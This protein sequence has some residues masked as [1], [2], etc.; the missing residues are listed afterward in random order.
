MDIRRAVG[1]VFFMAMLSLATGACTAD[2]DAVSPA[3]SPAQLIETVNKALADPRI[4]TQE[5]ARLL[6][7]R[8]L[9]REMLGERDDA[10]ADFT[11]AIAARALGTEEQA[12]ALYDRGVTLDELGRVDDAIA[13]YT[14]ALQ[15][16][17]TFA[18]AFNNRG[19][20][21]RRLGRLAEARRDYEASM[22]AGNPHSEYPEYGMGQIA[23]ALDQPSAAREYYRSALA[24]NPQFALAEE[25]L[26]A[27]DVGSLSPI[28]VKKP[29]HRRAVALRRPAASASSD[30]GP[31]LKPTINDADAAAGPY[32]QLGAYRTTGEANEAWDRVQQGAG[33]LL[34]GLTPVIVAIDLRGRGRYYR[35]RVAQPSPATA[36]HLCQALRAKG[37][38]CVLLRG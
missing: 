6:V 9:A 3:A 30:R 35:L 20:A 28:A 27:M 15:L 33:E 24:T 1:C 22:S 29:G 21:L 18:A 31:N 7:R 13:D 32:I 23:E 38:T 5:K 16:E 2:P 34:S 14:S 17:P 36:G 4:Q 25:R 12:T 26:V 10:L 8:G 11:G 19:N 37:I